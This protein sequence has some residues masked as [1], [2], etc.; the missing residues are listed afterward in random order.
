MSRFRCPEK[1]VFERILQQG[2][3]D[4]GRNKSVTTSDAITS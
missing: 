2:L 4:K 3:E 1:P